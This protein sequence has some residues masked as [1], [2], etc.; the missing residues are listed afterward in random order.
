MKH[1]RCFFV[2]LSALVL[3][4][5]GCDDPDTVKDTGTGHV[6]APQTG[7]VTDIDGN[8]Y[9]TIRVGDTWWMAENL[10]TTRY[11][12]GDALL[13]GFSASDFET[14]TSGAYTVFPYAEVSGIDSDEDMAD[15][16][17]MLYNGYA[18]HDDRGLCPAGWYVPGDNDWKKLEDHLGGWGVAGGKMKSI[19]TAPDPHPRWQSPNTGADDAI[20]F[21]ALPGGIMTLDADAEKI[22]RQGH[23]WTSARLE[24][25]SALGRVIYFNNA[26]LGA[27]DY[28]NNM[29]LSV[30][31][32]KK[33]TDPDM[34][35]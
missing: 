7:V 20:N 14:K 12:N 33:S 5:T 17:G 35:R 34:V 11:A 8:T 1:F 15:A 23:W 26:F 13:S 21:S 10:R 6:S 27:R 18:V 30:R 3:L 9:P 29:G 16:Y 22:G 25:D 24:S 28:P 32:V 2:I 19:R 4:C 31:C